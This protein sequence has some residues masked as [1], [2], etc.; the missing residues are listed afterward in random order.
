MV[1][2]ISNTTNMGYNVRTGSKRYLYK[3]KENQQT[4]KTQAFSN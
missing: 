4:K 2:N 1:T 3:R